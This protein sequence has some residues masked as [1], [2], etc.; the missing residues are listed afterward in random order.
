MDPMQVADKR[1]MFQP[2]EPPPLQCPLGW[3]RAC[4]ANGACVCLAP[5]P[6]ACEVV[7]VYPAGYPAAAQIP[8]RDAHCDQAGFELALA[9]ILAKL[10]GAP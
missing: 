7:I 8:P 10:L 9:V 2:P 3:V 5:P 6:R 1:S 4:D